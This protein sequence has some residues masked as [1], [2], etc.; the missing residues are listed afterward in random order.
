MMQLVAPRR[1]VVILVGLCAAGPLLGRAAAESNAIRKHA[2]VVGV[3][4]YESGK[5][6]PLQFTENDAEELARVLSEQ[7]LFTSVRVLT[8]TRGKKNPADAPTRANLRNALRTL[9]AK[10]G[11]DDLVLVALAG[12]GIQAKVGPR[13]QTDESFFC[14]ADAQ[15]NNLGTMLPFGKLFNDLDRC[16]AGVK[17]LLVDACRNDPT[18]G[19]NVDV[20]TLPRLPRGTATLFSCK[21]GERAFESKKLGKGHGIFFYHVIQGLRGEARNREGEVTWGNLAEHVTRAVSDDVPKLI[22][23]GARQTPE[24]KVN[25]TGKSPLLVPSPGLRV[26]A[27]NGAGWKARHEKFVARARKGNVDLLFLGDGLVA[28]WD[29]PGKKTWAE[30]FEPLKAACFGIGGDQTGHVLWRITAGKELDGI[31]PKL[32]VVL[33]GT[34]NTG[35]G[36]SNEQIAAGIRA[37]VEELRRQKPSTKILLLGLLPRAIR[38]TDKGGN[39]LDARQLLH[40]VKRINTLLAKLADGTTIVFKDIGDRYVDKDGGLSKEVMPD[41]VHLSPKGYQLFADAIKNDV[42]KLLK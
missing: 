35:V 11:R 24:L 19:R 31:N 30:A 20:E 28:G 10:K 18:I 4:D 37:V 42:K 2:L 5:F 7:A 15:L 41:F 12:H 32:A 9:L 34:S 38:G 26:V 14:P 29:G 13:K 33:V 16:G 21:S 6:D 1:W 40:R 39:H 3:R 23:G 8:T 25:L 27:R 36:H 22:G 17:L